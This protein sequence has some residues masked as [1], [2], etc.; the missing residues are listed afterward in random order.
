MYKNIKLRIQ[1]VLDRGTVDV[2][3]IN[4]ARMINAFSKWTPEFT[5]H[6][7]PT[8]IEVY[9]SLVLNMV[10]NLFFLNFIG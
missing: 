9:T 6:Q 2:D 5:R 7:H 8:V 1:D 3:Q 4:N 10:T